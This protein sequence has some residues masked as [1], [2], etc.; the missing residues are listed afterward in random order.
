MYS[1]FWSET[2]SEKKYGKFFSGNRKKSLSPKLAILKDFFFYCIEISV[3][4]TEFSICVTK[5][6][7]NMAN[8]GLSEFFLFPEKNLPYF[9]SEC[10][11]KKQD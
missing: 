7:F 1:S 10:S 5:K 4:N 6:S 8:F 11:L 9:F 2:H 3:T